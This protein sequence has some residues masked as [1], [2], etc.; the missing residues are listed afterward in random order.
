MV[1]DMKSVIG[2]ETQNP[3]CL[4]GIRTGGVLFVSNIGYANPIITLDAL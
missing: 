2:L 1:N 3:V 4:V